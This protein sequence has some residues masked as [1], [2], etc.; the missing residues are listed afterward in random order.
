[1]DPLRDG[2]LTIEVQPTSAGLKLSWLG[3][4]NSRTPGRALQP[5]FETVFAEARTRGGGVEM[6]FNQLEHFNSSTIAALIQ[7]INT[8]R[9][10]EV[11]MTIR[12]DGGRNWQ[13]LS[14]EALKRA[15]RPFEATSGTTR[16]T[17]TFLGS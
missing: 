8:A 13:V 9:E 1:M 5:F 6:V 11:A 4:S 10:R 7:I 3:R 12:Y 2:D 14:F 15:L 16:G 17:V